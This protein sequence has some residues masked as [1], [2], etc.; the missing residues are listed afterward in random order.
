ME[1]NSL[2]ESTVMSGLEV[3]STPV[4]VQNKESSKSADIDDS[5]IQVTPPVIN[6]NKQSEDKDMIKM[7]QLLFSEQSV[8]LNELSSDFNNK[9]DNNDVKFNEFKSEFNN[10]FDNKF[11][12]LKTDINKV[13]I[14]CESN[15]IKWKYELNETLSHSLKILNNKS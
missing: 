11:D 3:H 5:G 6:K 12:E 9:F 10:K 15:F 14:K 2:T 13:Q 1:S 8:K 4:P 7:M